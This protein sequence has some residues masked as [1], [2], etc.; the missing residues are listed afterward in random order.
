MK[1]LLL[2]L[3]N[4]FKVFNLGKDGTVTLNSEEIARGASKVIN[5][6]DKIGFFGKDFL[7]ETKDEVKRKSDILVS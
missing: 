4:Q 5:S 7:L 1:L 6:G 2:S 3:Q